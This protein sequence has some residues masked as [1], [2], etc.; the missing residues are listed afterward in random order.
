VIIA[1]LAEIAIF[2]G[3]IDADVPVLGTAVIGLVVLVGRLVIDSAS[4]N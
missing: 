1:I 4:P 3:V 2:R